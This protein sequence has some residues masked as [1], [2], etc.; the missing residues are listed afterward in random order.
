[1]SLMRYPMDFYA[2]FIY[3]DTK[4][5]ST[6]KERRIFFSVRT[7]LGSIKWNAQ[8]HVLVVY[9]C[10][11]PG[12]HPPPLSSVP[13]HIIAFMYNGILRTYVW[14]AAKERDKSMH[15]A[16]IHRARH[17]YEQRNILYARQ[18]SQP[19][20]GH[21]T[22]GGSESVLEC[23][24]A[25]APTDSCGKLNG[26][27]WNGENRIN[28]TR[29]FCTLLLFL[30]RFFADIGEHSS[31]LTDRKRHTNTS[32]VEWEKE[33]TYHHDSKVFYRHLNAIY[34]R[35]DLVHSSGRRRWWLRRP[36]FERIWRHL[37]PANV[38]IIHFSIFKRR[39]CVCVLYEC[40]TKRQK[41][42]R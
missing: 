10:H 34:V 33:I 26:N 14:S 30:C 32:A 29:A 37:S 38:S 19:N 9:F 39:V 24:L 4:I 25:C 36:L 22:M 8:T 3:D 40:I 1:M 5:S 21:G 6:M 27:N 35:L 41:K 28:G 42:N 12:N 11:Q 15:N 2:R 7:S 31:E 17:I 23:A 16:Q 13:V 20:K 18:K